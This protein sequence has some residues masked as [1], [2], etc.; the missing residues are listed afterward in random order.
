MYII[1]GALGSP[2]S[3]KMRALMRYRR[4]AHIWQHGAVTHGHAI[5]KVRAPVIPVIEYPDGTFHNDSTSLI[6]D[7]ER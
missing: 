4:I 2:Y 7:L 1:N 5:A 6:Y 3:L